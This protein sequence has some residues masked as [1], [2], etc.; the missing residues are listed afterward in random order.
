MAKL[1]LLKKIVLSFPLIF[2]QLIYASEGNVK[3]P[4]R[5]ID[6]IVRVLDRKTADA[7]PLVDARNMVAK[8]VPKSAS[9]EEMN[10][11]FRNRSEAYARLGDIDKAIKDLTQSIRQY[12]GRSNTFRTSDLLALGAYEASI[13]NLN[14][15]ITVTLEARSLIRSNEWGQFLSIDNALAGYYSEL[16]D[17]KQAEF[18]LADA[19]STVVALKRSPIFSQMG[20][21][22]TAQYM[23]GQGA[24]L[25]YQGRW[26][27]AE[28][29]LNQSVPY[30]Q[31]WLASIRLHPYNTEGADPSGNSVGTAYLI[32]NVITK[33]TSGQSMLAQA[34]AAQGKLIEAEVVMREAFE[35][36][37]DYFGKNTIQA[38]TGL[39]NLGYVLAEQNRLDEASTLTQ[40]ALSIYKSA[41]ASEEALPVIK[42]K[43][44]LAKYM[45]A[46]HKYDQA[47]KLFTELAD[48]IQALDQV[49][50]KV[51]VSDIDWA[52]AKAKLGQPQAAYQMTQELL[53]VISR[54]SNP[55][56]KR[57]A[58]LSSI[59]A[60][61]LHA[62]GRDE[63]A[64]ALYSKSMPALLSALEVDAENQTGGNREQER[65][66]IVLE[67]H[68]STLAALSTSKKE[69]Y[70]RYADEAFMLA[71][72]AR[73]SGVQRA[74]T[75]SA[76]RANI[77]DPKL[78]EL[79]R[80]EQDTQRRIASLE[81][82][83][84]D[85]M[86][87]PP[88]QQL[89]AIQSKM[90]Q[91]IG[92][93]KQQREGLR[94]E[95]EQKFPD[96]ADLVNPKPTTIDKVKKQ[97]R[98]DEVLVS[99]YF[100]DKEGFVWAISKNGAPQFH[101]I[102]MG[103]N[104]MAQSVA[105][106]RKALDPGVA[107]IDDIPSFDTV[108]SNQLYQSLMLPVQ[109]SLQGKK[110]L[111]AV[112]HGELGQLP[113]SLLVTQG[114]GTTP[115]TK[116]SDFSEYRQTAWL[117]KEIAITQLPSVTSL[118]SLRN[119][120]TP[121]ANRR[122]FVGFGDPYFSTVQAKQA[123][124]QAAR[125]AKTMAMRGVPLNLRSAPKTSLVSSAEL[126][127]LPRLPDTKDEIEQIGKAL[128]ADPAQDIFLEE[129]ASVTK[130]LEM[131]FSN[132]K[133]VMFATHGLVPGELDGLTQPALALSA[134]AVTGEQ[135]GDGLLTMEKILTLNLNADWVVLSACNTASGEG[136]GSEAVSGLGRA[137]FYAGARALLVSNW[138]VDSE[139]SRLLMTDL[140]KRQ[141]L[142][143]GQHKAVYLREAMLDMIQ[144]GA[145][146]DSAGK[147]KYTYAHPL[148]WAP[149]VVVGD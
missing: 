34:F 37:L 52:I 20:Q 126:A 63:Q 146:K 116:S 65:L 92:Q 49:G 57:I 125:V 117:T 36:T 64:Y 1:K 119:L 73:G 50:R 46:Q 138:P 86:S 54:Q 88:D 17:F 93:F 14:K 74:L 44:A 107:T 45:V 23:L 31:K 94:K 12:P 69:N 59:E 62:L 68:I 131:D 66:T 145:A 106:L 122:P 19:S 99:W 136:A 28:S 48:Q 108:L 149:F 103:R 134:P 96:Y 13:G 79:A 104:Q 51:P 83:L 89:P 8:E 80:T 21:W 4:P 58:S 27:E 2:S 109:S 6:D 18:Y 11:F 76:A 47:D 25:S 124:N 72:I 24:Y 7:D 118:A 15:A 38:G 143:Q 60:F 98:D 22:W 77:K 43:R 127:L 78:A 133:V 70:V 114:A 140:F 29:T 110:V 144:N 87:A 142:I 95:I 148:F 101:R 115:K 105:K 102:A 71:D 100:A 84:S 85:L 113:L 130:V 9:T 121:K 16:G 90:K 41:G 139:A 30:M 81:R 147:V 137:F 97:L 132:H 67:G 55:S 135:H 91:D 128:S 56:E 61:A 33:V 5:T 35:I 42:A 82:I 39:V 129:A 40:K 123:E 141:R 32:R 120:P 53:T 75:A 3:A 26:R 10:L 111:L 112:P